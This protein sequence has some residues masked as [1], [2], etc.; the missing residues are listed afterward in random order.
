MRANVPSRRG[1]RAAR[2]PDSGQP[3]RFCQ[4]Y[5]LPLPQANARRQLT[6]MPCR[7]PGVRSSRS[8]RR[9]TSPY[10]RA[11]VARRRASRTAI[12]ACN[13]QLSEQGRTPSGP[14]VC[15]CPQ[16]R[17][18]RK[19]PNGSAESQQPRGRKLRRRCYSGPQPIYSALDPQ[20]RVG[21]D[22]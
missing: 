5:R 7:G 1:H 15:M 13:R 12:E 17:A 20:R 19:R 22:G 21:S 16:H 18:Q 10:V 11:S 6:C 9:W 4:H 14:R 3:P 2:P 8:W